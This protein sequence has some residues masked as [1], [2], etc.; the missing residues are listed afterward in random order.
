MDAVDNIIDQ[1]AEG[2]KFKFLSEKHI[3]PE[4]LKCFIHSSP[5]Q[6]IKTV[7]HEFSAV[8]PFSGLPDLATIII[9]YYPFEKKAVELKSLKYYF[10]TFRNVG[11]YQE[12]VTTRIY[13][14]LKIALGFSKMSKLETP[15][16]V[17]SHYHVRGGFYTTCIE[18]TTDFHGHDIAYPANF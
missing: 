16:R 4:E 3:K 5:S 8:C 13:E 6:Y 18:G 11:I 1:K 9:E 17:T 7:T 14:D 10:L 15:L 12:A 2:K